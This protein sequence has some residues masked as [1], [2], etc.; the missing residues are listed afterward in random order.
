MPAKKKG[1]KRATTK[2]GSSGTLASVNRRLQRLE[3]HL[4]T[5]NGRV[6]RLEE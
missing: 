2:P 1:R 4:A 5:L 3:T 6:K